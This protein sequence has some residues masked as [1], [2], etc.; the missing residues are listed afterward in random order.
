MQ[1]YEEPK[2]STSPSKK[3]KKSNSPIGSGLGSEDST[4][5][6]EK[7]FPKKERKKKKKKEEQFHQ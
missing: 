7:G 2:S 5:D 6:G 3:R 4:S 1:S